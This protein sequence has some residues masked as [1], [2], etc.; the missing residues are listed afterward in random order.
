MFKCLSYLWAAPLG[1][2]HARAAH[3]GGGRG[4]GERKEEEED[5]PEGKQEDGIA[6]N[7][8]FCGQV[9]KK[10][11]DIARR[12]KYAPRQPQKAFF[13]FLMSGQS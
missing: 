10:T 13:W 5:S 1:A 11:R 9:M 7:Q 6:P 12:K 8:A 3:F 4:G 2:P